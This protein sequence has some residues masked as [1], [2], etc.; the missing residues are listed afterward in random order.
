MEYN[1]GYGMQ[2]LIFCSFRPSLNSC[3]AAPCLQGATGRVRLKMTS[4]RVYHDD[5]EF[6]FCDDVNKYEKLAKIG[7]GT[8]G[9][10]FV[11][12]NLM[13]KV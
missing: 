2:V 5:L 3:S 11:S 12:L 9:Y 6:P 10:V 8:F 4:P 13:W 7:Q 1:F